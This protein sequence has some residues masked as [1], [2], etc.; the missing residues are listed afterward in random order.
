MLYKLGKITAKSK[1][2]FI[3]ESNYTGFVVYAPDIERFEIDKFQKVFIYHHQNEYI[4]YYYGFKDF[5]ERIFFEDLLAIQGIG[6]KTA[7]SILNGGWEN[8]LN[9][10]IEGN[11]EALAK[12]PFLGTKTARQIIFEYQGKYTNIMNKKFESKNKEELKKTLKILG[13]KSNQIEFALKEIKEN[14][15]LEIMIEEAVKLISDEQ[16]NKNII[17]KA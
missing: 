17:I 5:K 15:N 9:F 13:F 7:V 1:G 4:D 12:L 6:P 8:A 16:R 11:W 3:L 2:Y 10:I 14:D